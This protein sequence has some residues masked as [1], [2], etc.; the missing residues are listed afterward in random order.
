VFVRAIDLQRAAAPRVRR[1]P[2]FGRQ[3]SAIFM[4][5]APASIRL[6]VGS[7]VP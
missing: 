5:Q 7:D 1:Q 6:A 3:A 2:G 4:A